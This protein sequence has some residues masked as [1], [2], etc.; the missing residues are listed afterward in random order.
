MQVR[1]TSD[2][3]VVTATIS[4]SKDAE[5]DSLEKIATIIITKSIMIA[6]I[7]ILGASK[8]GVRVL[9]SVV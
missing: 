8:N 3:I 2:T 1:E 6:I 7:P 5:I 9:I 4:V